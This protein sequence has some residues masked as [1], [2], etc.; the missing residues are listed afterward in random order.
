MKY[1]RTKDKIYNTKEL[2][3]ADYLTDNPY[4]NKH[5]AC[6]YKNTI[7]SKA[8]TIEELCDEFVMLCLCDNN[9]NKQSPI[10]MQNLSLLIGCMDANYGYAIYGAIWTIGEHGEPILKAVARM[11]ENGDFELL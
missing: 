3:A 9:G 1:I 7:I 4:V 10:I 8:D 2:R 6:I 5:G 11:N